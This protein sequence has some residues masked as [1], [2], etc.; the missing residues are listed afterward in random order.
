M[1]HVKEAKNSLGVQMMK[2]EGF[3][4]LGVGCIRNDTVLLFYVEKHKTGIAIFF[5]LIYQVINNVFWWVRAFQK[6]TI[7]GH[8]SSTGNLTLRFSE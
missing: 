2:S 4:D 6:N 7:G 5:F 8:R 1:K 3:Q